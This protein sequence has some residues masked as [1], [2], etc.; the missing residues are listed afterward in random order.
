MVTSPRPVRDLAYASLRGVGLATAAFRE[1]PDFLIIGAQRCGTGSLYAYLRAHPRIAG[2]RAKEVHYFDLHPMRSLT[3]YRAHF[4]TRARHIYVHRRYGGDLVVGEATPAYLLLPATPAKVLEM[5]EHVKLIALLRDP[6]DRAF[7]AWHLGRFYGSE[8][9]SFEEAL[10]AEEE[11]LAG[12]Y[13][14]LVR[15]PTYVSVP[16]Q[17][18]SYLARGRYAEQLSRWLEVFPQGQVLVLASERLYAD[19]RNV[20]RQVFDF[21]GLPE[22]HRPAYPR[23]G[24]Q[25][26]ASMSQTTRDRLTRYFTPHNALLYDLVGEDFGWSR[27]SAGAG[28]AAPIPWSATAAS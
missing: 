21:L 22:L 24:S 26:R 12:E 8:S 14:K 17:T 23:L 6:V 18:Y 16:Y 10:D 2:P 9:L 28:V 20:V 25:T 13:E 7:S 4:P 15:D 27:A 5:N 1:L 19:T 3:W 11:R